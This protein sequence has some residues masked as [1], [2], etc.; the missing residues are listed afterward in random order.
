MCKVNKKTT[1]QLSSVFIV[2]FERQNVQSDWFELRNIQYVLA[3]F[4][5]EPNLALWQVIF[6][7]SSLLYPFFALFLSFLSYF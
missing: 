7:Y 3:D 1:E 2:N 6:S 5:V 4:M